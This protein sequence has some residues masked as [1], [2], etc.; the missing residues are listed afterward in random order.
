[1]RRNVPLADAFNF[2]LLNFFSLFGNFFVV[3]T[4]GVAR[5]LVAR[6]FTRVGFVC[7]RRCS[8]LTKSRVSLLLLLVVAHRFD[9]WWFFFSLSCVRR[10][11]AT[12]AAAQQQNKSSRNEMLSRRV[13]K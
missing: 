12:A 4:C 1:V 5:A 11:F 13:L 6:R 3:A 10:L 8:S 2:V 9:F 7:W